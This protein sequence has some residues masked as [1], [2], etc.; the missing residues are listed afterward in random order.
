VRI[1]GNRIVETFGRRPAPATGA[2]RNYMRYRGNVLRFGRLTMH[3]A[4]MELIDE[5][6]RDPFE[7]SPAGYV[8]QLVAGYSKNAADGSLRVYMPDLD[9]AGR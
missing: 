5:D 3:D 6:Q 1:E 4:D 2:I 8:K 9:E 7:F